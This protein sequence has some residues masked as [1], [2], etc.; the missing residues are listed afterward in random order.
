MNI[1]DSITV[2]IESF[3]MKEVTFSLMSITPSIW[4]LFVEIETSFRDKLLTVRFPAKADILDTWENSLATEFLTANI[5]EY[6]YFPKAI[7]DRMD[8][9]VEI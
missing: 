1:A 2:E 5:D 4:S 9:I 8:Q 7:T 6:L 3:S